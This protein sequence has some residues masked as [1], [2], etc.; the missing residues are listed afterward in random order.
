MWGRYGIW[1]ETEQNAKEY[2]AQLKEQHSLEDADLAL[3]DEHTDDKEIDEYD[4]GFD[5]YDTRICVE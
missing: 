1:Y 2:I 3:D 4:G 5:K